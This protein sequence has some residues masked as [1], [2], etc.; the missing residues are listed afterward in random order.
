MFLRLK[1]WLCRL[2]WHNFRELPYDNGIWRVTRCIRCAVRKQD[3]W[4]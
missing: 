1:S 2:G 3:R 4:V